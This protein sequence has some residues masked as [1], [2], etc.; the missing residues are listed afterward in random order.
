MPAVV[1]WDEE[2][3]QRVREESTV[4]MD[5]MG[6]NFYERKLQPGCTYPSAKK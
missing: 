4:H 3:D 1:Q 2:M 6:Q 5:S